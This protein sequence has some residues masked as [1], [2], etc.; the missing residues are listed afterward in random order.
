AGLF[1]DMAVRIINNLHERDK[2]PIVVGGTGLYIKTL[3]RGLFE[4]PSADWVLREKLIGEEKI[5]GTGHLYERLRKIDPASADKINPADTRRI[6]R[7][8]EVSLKGKKAISELQ[9]SFTTRQ[10]YEFI[11]IGLYRERKELY[12]MIEQRVDKMME[13]GL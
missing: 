12:R 3:T 6:I 1:R 7:A 2:I 11:K 10:P 9:R 13:K 4:G 8:I 5:H